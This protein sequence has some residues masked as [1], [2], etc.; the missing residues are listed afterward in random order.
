MIFSARRQDGEGHAWCATPWN[1]F[2]PSWCKG[3]GRCSVNIGQALSQWCLARALPLSLIL[4]A[5]LICH[6]DETEA[7]WNIV[8]I[9][10]LFKNQPDARTEP[11]K[12]SGSSFRGLYF[13]QHS[14]DCRAL[15]EFISIVCSFHK[16]YII[17]TEASS[18]FKS[19]PKSVLLIRKYC[20]LVAEIQ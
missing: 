12:N 1:A 17:L 7:V 14:S 13:A 15:K 11:S 3:T 9:D 6:C 2:H 4:A 16:H 10:V 8:W 5:P 18:R 20:G 19:R